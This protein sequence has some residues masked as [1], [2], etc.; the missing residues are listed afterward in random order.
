MSAALYGG[1][2]T[3]QGSFRHSVL[4]FS[5]LGGD[6][7]RGTAVLLSESHED[8]YLDQWEDRGLSARNAASNT[9]PVEEESVI[10]PVGIPPAEVQ[11]SLRVAVIGLPNAGKS[12]LVNQLVQKKVKRME[13]VCVL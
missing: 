7:G 3:G 4:R 9:G 8:P 13:R 2:G 11:R 1:T 5:S 12:T 6:G 10:S